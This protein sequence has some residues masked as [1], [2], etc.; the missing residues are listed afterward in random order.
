M[1]ATDVWDVTFV[2]LISCCGIG[3]HLCN[4]SD[5]FAAQREDDQHPASLNL[6]SSSF[7]LRAWDRPLQAKELL[8]FL[9]EGSHLL[10]GYEESEVKDT[11]HSKKYPS[12]MLSAFP[13]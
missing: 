8:I 11:E 5:T 2:S 1:T 3:W 12:T 6:T 4:Q 13:G 9:L 7:P 10:K